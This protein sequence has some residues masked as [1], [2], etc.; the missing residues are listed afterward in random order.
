MTLHT[1]H[2]PGTQCRQYLS[3]YW[4]DFDQTLKVSSWDHLWQIPAV[5]MT[6]VLA[7]FVY[8][9]NITAVTDPIWQHF[10]NPIFCRPWTRILFGP[11]ICLTQTFFNLE[12]Y[13]TQ[14][15]V[16]HKYWEP[17]FYDLYFFALDFLDPHFFV[18][19][20]FWTFKIFVD[21]KIFW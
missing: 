4:S 21:Q 6:F 13:W 18:S 9:R 11:K 16:D 8:I 5:T 20:T 7:T 3:C 12:I 2:P 10:L 14:N 17:I 1:H 15:L 19:K